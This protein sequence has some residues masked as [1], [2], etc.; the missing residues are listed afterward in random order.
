[1]S[2]DR[3]LWVDTVKAIG[4]FFIVLGH[5][6]PPYISAWIYTFNVPLF[7][8]M[9]GFLAKKEENWS[10]FFRKNLN[11]L[12]IPF[13]LLSVIINVPYLIANFTDCHK[14]LY[15]LVGILGGFHS[16]DGM[17]G[18][19]NMWFVYCLLVVKIMF[20][21]SSFNKHSLMGA[22][23]C[24]IAGM[25]AYHLSGVHYKWA[26]S[27][28]LYAFPYF[29]LGFWMKKK[30]WAKFLFCNI[31]SCKLNFALSALA[32]SSAFVAS[33]NGVA[34]T[35]EGGVGKS[36]IV[37]TLCSVINIVAMIRFS[38][39]IQHFK[40]GI[41]CTISQGSIII[42]AFHLW[43]VYPMGRVVT[44]FL[45]DIPVLESTVLIMASVIICLVF[46]PII[47]LVKT[48]IP[49]LMGKR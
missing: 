3:I 7:F 9:S 10:A 26:V 1:M 13:V 32:L 34:Y 23:A 4:M 17:N 43:F 30:D 11:G 24:C 22:S 45:K 14:M 28:V 25:V 2:K 42:L 20:Q 38:Y 6:F 47:K 33:Y 49:V 27:N 5:F 18:C 29:V 36:L 46:V 8:V 12:I 44:H 19:M 21:C 37:M 35:Y 40:S 41:M 16:I 15:C 39:A 31:K 48:Y